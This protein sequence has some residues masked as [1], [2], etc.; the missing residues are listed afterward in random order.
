MRRSTQHKVVSLATLT[1][2]VRRAKRAGRRVVFTN[3]CFDLLHV[4]HVQL[5]ERAKTLGE[6]LV[7]AINSDRSVRALKGPRRPVVT[8]AARAQV[9]AA[10]AAVDY[11]TIFDQPTPQQLIE[12]LRPDVLV[13]GADWGASAIVGREAM[14]RRGGRVVRIPLRRG[15]STTRLIERIR[16]RS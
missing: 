12:R 11:V 16:A 1:G 10:L 8:Q 15:C 6:L 13:K 3:G 2:L 5:L 9:L 7:V 14:R 4:G